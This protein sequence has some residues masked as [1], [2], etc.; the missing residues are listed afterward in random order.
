MSQYE[1]LL[2]SILSGTKDKSQL[3]TDLQTVLDHLDSKMRSKRGV[4]PQI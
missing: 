1:K 3:F 4:A 2:L